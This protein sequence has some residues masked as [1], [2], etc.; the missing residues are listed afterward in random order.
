[1]TLATTSVRKLDVSEASARVEGGAAFIDLRPTSSYLDVHIPGSLALKYEFGP[2]MP[3]R[4]RDCI[5]LEVPFV[6]LHHEGLDTQAVT[7]AF[8]GK[9]FT[10]LGYVEEGLTAWGHLHGA[11]ASTEVVAD[12]K[13]PADVVLD[14][15]DPGV[16]LYEDALLIS[17]EK[18]WSR[19][20]EITADRVAILAGRGVRASLA[21]GMLERAGI[22]DIAFWT[23]TALPTS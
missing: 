11:P 3:G 17:V 18:L 10:V 14:V 1:M 8:R 7:A 13:P 4:A 23:H 12:A 9:G 21:V 5:P 22:T 15:G 16:R 20:D 19:T 2:G 6:L